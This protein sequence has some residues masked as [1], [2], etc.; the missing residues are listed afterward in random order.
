MIK[1]ITYIAP[2]KTALTVSIVIALSSLLLI[3]PMLLSFSFM[4][5]TDQNGNPI[6]TKFPF[7]FFLIMMPVFYFIFSYLVISLISWLYNKVAKFTGG[8]KYEASE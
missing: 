2:H 3:V 8:I 5:M 7:V 1:S 6:N 4:P